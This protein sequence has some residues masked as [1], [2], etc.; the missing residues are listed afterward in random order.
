MSAVQPAK[1]N[2]AP[3]VRQRHLRAWPI[4]RF[5]VALCLF[6]HVAPPVAVNDRYPQ[7][8]GGPTSV[9]GSGILKNDSVPCGSSV[10]VA[11]VSPPAHGTLTAI[12]DDGSFTYQPTGAQVDDQYTYEITCNGLVS[13]VAMVFLP[14]PP[15]EW[16][17]A[18][19]LAQAA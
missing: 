10:T 4:L 17:A 13:N 16:F 18:L 11:V 2:I 19:A 15:C 12:G 6:R 5:C 8:P 9:P 1:I 7:T 14:A 3:H